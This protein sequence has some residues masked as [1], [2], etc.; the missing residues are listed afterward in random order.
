[1]NI[2]PLSNDPSQA[3]STS[4]DETIYNFN[5]KW[6]SLGKY[7]TMDI[8]NDEVDH[9]G[10]KLVSGIDLVQKYADLDF[11][12]KSNNR[13]DPTRNNLNKFKNT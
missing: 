9:K 7:W 6:N 5:I 12:L 3:L 1:M 4:I 13:L 2:I 10:I 11:S 8:F